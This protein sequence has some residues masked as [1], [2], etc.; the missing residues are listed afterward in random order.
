MPSLQ[1]HQ[2]RV[3]AVAKMIC[4]SSTNDLDTQSV[5]LACLFHDM[6]NI[7]KSDL[8]YFPDFTEPEGFAHWELIKKGYVQKYGSNHHV[9]TNMIVKEI[10]LPDRILELIKGIGYSNIGHIVAGHDMEQKISEYADVRVGPHGVLSLKNR[11][12][13]GR[14]RYL[15]TRSK[16]PYYDTDEGFAEL[17]DA[18]EK[19]E[20]Q[21]FADATIAPEDI[22]EA[23]ITPSIEELREYAVFS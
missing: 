22:T 13:E 6:G 20:K 4:E 9:A 10:G 1:L 11:L 12:A 15:E 5:I 18:A 21:V 8:T 2:L 19:L 23:A 16:R 7:I 17:S 3:A 14:E